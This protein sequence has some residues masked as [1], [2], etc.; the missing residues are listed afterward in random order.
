VFDVEPPKEMVD[1]IEEEDVID[2]DVLDVGYS[3]RNNRLG[4][5]EE[6]RRRRFSSAVPNY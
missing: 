2:E 4:V 1:E 3:T 5:P 6:L